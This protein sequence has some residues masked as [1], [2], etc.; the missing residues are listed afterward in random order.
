MLYF[1][2]VILFFLASNIENVPWQDQITQMNVQIAEL[3]ETQDRY[4]SSV[5]KNINNAMRWQ[6]QN[7]NYADAR[8][9][10]EKVA[11]EK[12]KVKEIQE[13][14]DDLEIRKAEI[15]REHGQR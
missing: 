9:A 13:Q 5:E 3:K 12:Q 7:E 2:S 4:R 11:A 8:R 10:W 15:L 14:I 6:F 1:F